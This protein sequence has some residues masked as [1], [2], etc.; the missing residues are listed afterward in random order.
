M[1]QSRYTSEGRGPRA[2]ELR[3]ILRK[4]FSLHVSYW[5]AWRAREI[6]LDNAMGTSMGSYA[7]IAPYYELLLKTNPNSVVAMETE[8]DS[9]G[10]ERFKYLFFS[11]DACAKGYAYMRKVVVID[12]THL[13]GRFGG[14]LMA[15]CAQDGNFQLF[16]L[17]FAIVNSEN[18]DAWCWFLDHLT[19]IVPD[20]P[21][22]VFVSDRHAS[23]YTAI[24]KVTSEKLVIISVF[25][26]IDNIVGGILI[27]VG[28][29]LINLIFM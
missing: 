2:N 15:A 4:E 23:I 11:L 22:L 25:F 19:K 7:L 29:I 10:K 14:C 3:R 12:G 1:M 8:R 18:D 17:A 24:R 9:T 13:Q 26:V 20:E 16:P 28:R 5:K 27:N 21:E 6:A